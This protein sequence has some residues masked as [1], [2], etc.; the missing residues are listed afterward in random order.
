MPVGDQE[1][2]VIA[3]VKAVLKSQGRNPPYDTTQKMNGNPVFGYQ[4]E[5][6]IMFLR[7]VKTCLARKG[8]TYTYNE[9]T[10]YMN[11]TLVMT[12]AEI[13]AEIDVNTTPSARVPAGPAQTAIIGA[14]A[15]AAAPKSAKKKAAKPARAKTKPRLRKKKAAKKKPAKKA[16]AASA[17]KKKAAKR[18]K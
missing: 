16:A 14:P 13:Y 4:V 5:T 2:I 17:A 9:T 6:M 10:D 12:L 15:P 8:Y 3:C 11:Q 1:A 7:K 18:R